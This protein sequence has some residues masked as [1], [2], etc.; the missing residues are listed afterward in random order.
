M[1]AR[2]C[3]IFSV[4]LILSSC[5]LSQTTNAT[6]RGTVTDASGGAIAGATVTLLE[7]RTGQTVGHATSNNG[8]DFEFVELKPGTYE[9][10]CTAS[11]FKEFV[12][13]DIVLDTGQIRRLDPQL[14]AG[15]TV[16]QVTVSAGA[17]VIQYGI[18]YAL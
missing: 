6:L 1:F 15:S 17:S 14:A 9:L 18:G 7:P 4:A 13:Q 5:A 16:E 11:S 8:G 12:A 10:R 3:A 2:L